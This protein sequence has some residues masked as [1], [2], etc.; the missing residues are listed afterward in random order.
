LKRCYSLSSS[1][2][3]STGTGIS[4]YGHL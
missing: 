1:T 4:R 3:R 2:P